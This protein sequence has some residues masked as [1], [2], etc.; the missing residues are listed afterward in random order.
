[1]HANAI[2]PIAAAESVRGESICGAPWRCGTIRTKESAQIG[3]RMKNTLLSLTCTVGACTLLSPTCAWA[4]MGL[5]QE[6]TS[7]GAITYF[8]FNGIGYVI[9][10]VVA[11]VVI[12]RKQRTAIKRMAANK[13]K[14][15]AE[16]QAAS[17]ASTGSDAQEDLGASTLAAVERLKQAEQAL[18][19][20]QK[21]AAR[22][23]G[24]QDDANKHDAN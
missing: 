8:D 6:V 23:R 3:R 14:R 20:P 9:I 12:V 10:L 7:E 15:A 22:S 18:H 17:A 21:T 13:R 24:Q 19:E 2:R 5:K 4:E 1:M 11:L 16:R